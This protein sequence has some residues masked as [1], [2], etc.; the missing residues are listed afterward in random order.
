MTL[1][2]TGTMYVTRSYLCGVLVILLGKELVETVTMVTVLVLSNHG[3][4]VS[5]HGY[6]VSGKI[7]VLLFETFLFLMCLLSCAGGY[8]TACTIA[9]VVSLGEWNTSHCVSVVTSRTQQIRSQPIT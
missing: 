2:F 6:R 4:R 9:V 8:I 7:P 3:Y 1:V 5:N